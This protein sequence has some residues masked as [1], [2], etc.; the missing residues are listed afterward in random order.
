MIKLGPKVWPPEETC[1][2]YSSPAADSIVFRWNLSETRILAEKLKKNT[3]CAR[4]LNSEPAGGWS[5]E[6]VKSTFDGNMWQKYWYC[7]TIHKCCLVLEGI[8]WYCI[9]WYY[10]NLPLMELCDS[11][12]CF[13]INSSAWLPRKYA[14]PAK[15]PTARL[16]QE[17]KRKHDTENAAAG[18]EKNFCWFTRAGIVYSEFFRVFPHSVLGG[19]PSGEEAIMSSILMPL[20]LLRLI[21]PKQ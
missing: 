16:T 6:Q 2:H 15:Y 5:Q 8:V 3:K 14:Q 17:K 11:S 20:P 9:V 1:I 21:S 10:I 18:K 19:C 4:S 13:S 7:I 12:L